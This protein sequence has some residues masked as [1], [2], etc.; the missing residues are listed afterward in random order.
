LY[1]DVNSS[2]IIADASNIRT[3]ENPSYSVEDFLNVYPQFGSISG[4][5]GYMSAELLQMYIDFA[6]ACV[7][8]A[9]YHSAWKICMGL[10]VAHF[11]SM[12]LQGTAAPGSSAGQVLAASQAKGLNTSESVGD[13]SVSMDYSNVG[14]DLDGWAQWKLTIYGQQLASIAKMLGKGGMVV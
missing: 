7:K 12:W 6:N 4:N 9:R 14:N 5:D 3:G 11:A 1:N 10:F 8:Q 2:Q 13:V